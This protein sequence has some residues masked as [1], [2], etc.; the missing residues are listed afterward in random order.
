[1]WCNLHAAHRQFVT[2]WSCARCC[3]LPAWAAKM[4]GVLPSLSARLGSTSSTSASSSNIGMKPLAV[5]WLSPVYN[6]RKH[7]T[8]SSHY[9]F[10]G[11]DHNHLL[12]LSFL[13][14]RYV[15]SRIKLSA[16]SKWKS[17]QRKY[18]GNN[19]DRH[20]EHM[21]TLSKFGECGTQGVGERGVGFN[22]LL[23]HHHVRLM[24]G[25]ARV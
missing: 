20:Y 3:L 13:F 9:R 16:F 7:F 23:F 25:N 8:F 4:S 10:L 14:H 11:H 18:S 17:L 15:A 19:K 6:A 2:T 5:A 24:W 12:P 21:I 22:F 1:M